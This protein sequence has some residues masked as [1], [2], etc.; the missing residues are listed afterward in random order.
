M[1]AVDTLTPTLTAADLAMVLLV[2]DDHD[3]T[4]RPLPT[5]RVKEVGPAVTGLARDGIGAVKVFAAGGRR[6]SYG[7]G[8][9]APDSI[10]AQTI[11]EVKAADSSMVVMTETCLCSWTAT[12]DCHIA[13]RFGRPDLAAT[14]DAMA[15]QAVAQ[16]DAGADIVGPAAMLPGSVRPVRQAL[17]GAG[18][19]AVRIMPHLIFSS[20]L[21]AG[22]RQ[23]MDA[24]PASGQRAFQID[25]CHPQAGIDAAL[26][27]VA[28]GADMLLLEPALCC[29]DVL[30]ALRRLSDVQLS[31]FS[32]S[33]EYTR[34]AGDGDWRL[35]REVFTFLKRSGSD[36]IITYAAAELARV[37]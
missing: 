7:A 2:R 33:G 35:L 16:A 30:I 24:A 31:P 34:L 26:A 28:E 15:A 3:L 21:Y 36:Q 29:A 14:I 32:V 8:G 6:D 20:Q 25:P 4:P 27:F 5:L 18:H 1:M 23:T 13:D 11:Q 10:M 12:G 19:C 17:D 22:Y 37:L 9:T